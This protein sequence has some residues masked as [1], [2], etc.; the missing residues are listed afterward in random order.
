M[1][2]AFEKMEVSEAR[3]KIVLYLNCPS[4]V[5]VGDVIFVKDEKGIR[6]VQTTT[7]LRVET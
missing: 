1:S 6:R 3:G 7:D 2:K 4:I 5:E